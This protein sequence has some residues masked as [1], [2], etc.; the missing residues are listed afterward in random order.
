MSDR[1]IVIL[2][3]D[4]QRAFGKSLIDAAPPGYV[5][6]LAEMTRT[7]EQNAKLWPMLADVR[8]ARPGDRQHTDETWKALFMHSLGHQQLFERALDDRGVVPLG[9]RSSQLGKRAFADL[10]ECIYEFGARHDV[11][12]SEPVQTE[13]RAA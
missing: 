4:V 5:M 13:R 8:K 6:T 11:R 10:I 2:E 9:F 12:W 1:R 3:T 7:L